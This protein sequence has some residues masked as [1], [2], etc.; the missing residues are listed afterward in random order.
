MYFPYLRGRQFELIAIR[1]LVES[2]LIGE[3]IIPVIEPVKPTSTLVK[4]LNVLSEM[5]HLHALVMNPEVGNFVSLYKEKKKTSDPVIDNLKEQL[6]SKYII[7][8]YL[9]NKN[10]PKQLKKKEDKEL[11][12]LMIVNPKRDCLDDFLSLYS[13]FEPAY[14]L[15]PDDRSFSRKTTKSKVIFMDRF[16]KAQRNADYSKN[17]DEFFSEDHLFFIK[18]GFKGFSDYSVVGADYN[19]SGFAPLA[20]AIHIVYFDKDNILKV[21]HFV[22]DSNEDI[23]DPAGKFGEALKKLSDWVDETDAIITKGLG[24]LLECHR[25]GKYPGLG[26]VKKYSIMHHLELMNK[27]FEGENVCR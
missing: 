22:S 10:I 20:V 6:K 3:N 8:T 14:T 7:K 11:E 12:K 19:E 2:G 5:A 17:E 26:T 25:N 15:I 21:H 18:E 23:Q 24:G 27:Y 9:M 4:T 13:R 16:P 1:E